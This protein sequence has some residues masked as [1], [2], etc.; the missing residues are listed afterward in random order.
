MI[1]IKAS[2]DNKKGILFESL[3]KAREKK[4]Q[5]HIEGMYES[6][7]AKIVPAGIMKFPAGRMHTAYAETRKTTTI[8]RP[9]W[10]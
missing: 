4:M 6:L 2:K 9:G 10:K 5:S 3:M 8:F 7:S 1:D